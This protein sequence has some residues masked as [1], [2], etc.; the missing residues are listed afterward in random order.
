MRELTVGHEE[1]KKHAFMLLHHE[2]VKKR[3]EGWR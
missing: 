3:N 1:S 2:K